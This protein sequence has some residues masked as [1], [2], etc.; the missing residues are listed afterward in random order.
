MSRL[1]KRSRGGSPPSVLFR[2]AAGPQ[3]G[4]GHLVRA[5]SL[6][7]SLHTTP[8]VALRGGR[9]ARATAR[10]LGC[11][12]TDESPTRAMTRHAPVVLVI[13]DPRASAAAGWVRAARRSGIPVAAM[14]D[15]GV[16]A[17]GTDLIIDGSLC[18]QTTRM[19]KDEGLRGPRYMVLDPVFRA[20][21]RRRLARVERGTVAIALGGGVH[22]RYARGVVDVLSQALGAERVR[23]APGFVS[24]GDGAHIACTGREQ[25]E[26]LVRAEVALVAGGVGLYEACC[27]GV[28]TVAVAVTQA[29]RR[30]IGSFARLGAVVD[31][32]TLEGQKNGIS[33]RT[34]RRLARQVMRVLDDPRARRRLASRARQVVDG[35]GGTRVARALQQLAAS[36][37][38][39]H[40]RAR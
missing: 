6:S 31:A 28:P 37:E 22:A 1:S 40:D 30:A 27:L 35:H 29:Q 33:P 24:R 3:I 2:V 39:Q 18:L 11:R 23:V 26:L 16:G 20:A 14:L 15:R 36:T 32:G 5:V 38:A 9:T 8:V 10:R 17:R 4:F 21:R 13:D 34:A 19:T 12:L 7:R 25:A